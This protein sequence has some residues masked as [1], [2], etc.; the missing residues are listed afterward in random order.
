M[1]S[2]PTQFVNVTVAAKANV[3]FDGNVVSHTV[4]MPDNSTFS[5]CRA[6]TIQ[7]ARDLYGNG[8]PAETALTQAWNAVG[9][10]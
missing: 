3:Y 9:V 7:A 1:S 6:M 4:L 8:S 10:F 5:I 2:S